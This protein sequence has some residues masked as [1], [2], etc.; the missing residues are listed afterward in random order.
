MRTSIV[1]GAALAAFVIAAPLHAQVVSA[2]VVL[3]AGPV[4]GH[5]VVNDPV[6]HRPP[7]VV[8]ERPARIIV[9]E[10]S[11]HP[12]LHRGWQRRGYR[13]MT[14]YYVDGRYYDR[15]DHRRPGMRKIVVYERNGRYYRDW[16]DRD[17]K[18]R[19]RYDR[20]RRDRDDYRD[21]DRDQ[22]RHRHGDTDRRGR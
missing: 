7:V 17:R 6:Y 15:Y 16:D 13:Q 12:G 3:R 5:V 9:V 14:V 2:D 8:H 18:D 19:D 11:R 10:R 21:R 4:R 20:E 1:A 22:G